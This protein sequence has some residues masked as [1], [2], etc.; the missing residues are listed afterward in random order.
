MEG[1]QQEAAPQDEGPPCWL[2]ASCDSTAAAADAE[3]AAVAEAQGAHHKWDL[4]P[5]QAGARTRPTPLV[6]DPAVVEDAPPQLVPMQGWLSA[7]GDATC[8][9]AHP[10]ASRFPVLPE[11]QTTRAAKQGGGDL[12]T[13]LWS[14]LPEEVRRLN[15]SLLH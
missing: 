8:G 2:P 5:R 1:K 6:V 13:G 7:G 14:L 3:G 10:P 15:L 12:D 4:N 9:S 11:V